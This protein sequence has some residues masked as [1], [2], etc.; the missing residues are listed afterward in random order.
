MNKFKVGDKVVRTN[1]KFGALEIGDEYTVREYTSDVCG[2]VVYLVGHRGVYRVENFELV[3]EEKPISKFKKGDKVVYTGASGHGLVHRL[4]YTVHHSSE[5]R[6]S[7]LLSKALCI[8]DEN[9]ELVKEEKPTLTPHECQKDII[10][11]ANGATIQYWSKHF[12][13]WVDVS[14]DRPHWISYIKYR[15][16]PDKSD[17]IEEEVAKLYEEID[18]NRKAINDLE[19][20]IVKLYSIGE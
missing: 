15:V 16:K 20:R 18:K 9:F 12:E 6:I 4:E 10:A 8:D 19:G 3:K 14:K 17:E 7:V 2:S 13:E 1:H 5:N 11:W